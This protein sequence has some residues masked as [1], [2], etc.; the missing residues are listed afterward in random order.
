ME[1]KTKKDRKKEDFQLD[2]AGTCQSQKSNPIPAKIPTC[3]P[4]PI[5]KPTVDLTTTNTH[6]DPSAQ[7]PRLPTSP[8]HNQRQNPTN[9]KHIRT[10]ECM[11]LRFPLLTNL[12][13]Q[14]THSSPKT[15]DHPRPD[16]VTE[17][18]NQPLTKLSRPQ[19]PLQISAK[20]QNQLKNP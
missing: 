18:P 15:K 8:N 10:P 9:A 13:N 14:L 12:Q 2:P 19:S 6:R 3:K 7:G 11:I 1:G 17:A 16:E 20:Y 4:D 5:H